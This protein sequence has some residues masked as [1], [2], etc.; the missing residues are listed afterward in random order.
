MREKAHKIEQLQEQLRRY[1]ELHTHLAQDED[2]TEQQSSSPSI[3]LPEKRGAAG[4]WSPTQQQPSTPGVPSEERF[5]VPFTNDSRFSRVQQH[6]CP[7]PTDQH[8]VNRPKTAKPQRM[9]FWL[10]GNSERTVTELVARA[11]NLP[12]EQYSASSPRNFP[13]LAAQQQMGF[14]QPINYQRTV[15]ETSAPSL[16]IEQQLANSPRPVTLQQIEFWQPKNCQRTVR[17]TP[18]PSLSMEDGIRSN[19]MLPQSPADLSATTY[20]DFAFDVAGS[21]NKSLQ[22]TS[23]L[24]MAVA[25]NHVDTLKVLLQ[26]ERV[27]VDELDSDGFTPLQRAVMQGKSE[28]VQLLLEYCADTGPVRGGDLPLGAFGGFELL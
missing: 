6:V 24:H 27:M 19:G 28:I 5:G 2:S 9:E 1:E 8:L 18:A 23:L 3:L 20:E 10:P 26:N 12:M 17:E 4:G 7:A 11:P 25:G 14:R 21:V 16:P 15:A 22:S 13:R